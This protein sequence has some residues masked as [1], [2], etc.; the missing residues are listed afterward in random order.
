MVSPL[1]LKYSVSASVSVE[2]GFDWI[3]GSTG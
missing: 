3:T 1:M 2:T